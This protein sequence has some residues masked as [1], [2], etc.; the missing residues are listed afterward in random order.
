MEGR[1]NS[2]GF[3]DTLAESYYAAGDIDQAVATIN[4]AASI[5]PEKAY[6]KIQK[7]KYE[8]GRK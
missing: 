3:I 2:P 8:K 1:P 4:H 5:E 6:Y 7:K